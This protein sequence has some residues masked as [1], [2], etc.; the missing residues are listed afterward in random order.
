MPRTK[1]IPP[2]GF[3]HLFSP[4]ACGPLTLKNRLVALPVHTGF[5]CP[6]G[7]VST[8]MEKFYTRLAASG[9]ALVVVANAA[10]SPD[11]VVS[12]FNLRADRDEFIPGLARLAA[13]V[14][15]R[16]A[17][18]CLQLNHAG[19][20]AKTQRPL[21]PSPIIAGNLAFNVESLK[22][23]MEFFPF[24]KRFGLTR[25]LISKIRTWGS[26]MTDDDRERVIRDF[27]AAAKRAAEAGFDMVELHGANGYLLCQYLSK[28]TNKLTNE[29]GGSKRRRAAFPLAVIREIKKQV[30]QGFPFGFR[31]ILNEWVPGG[32]RPEEAADFAR[33]LEKEDA[34]YLSVSA[35][36]YN[37]LFTLEVRKKMAVP[38]YLE[39]ETAGLARQITTPVIISGR[40]TTP[41]KA[42]SVIRKGSADL[43]G[44][45]R[46]LRAD[47]EWPAKARGSGKK[48]IP[49]INCN[50]CIKQVIL[51]K[52]FLCRQ[53]PRWRQEQTLLEHQLL[54][55]NRRSLWIAAHPTDLDTFKP[56]LPLLLP[57]EK[58]KSDHAILLRCD[59]LESQ[60][61][62][63]L[64]Q[65]FSAWLE[66]Q[67][68]PSGLS[69]IPRTHTLAASLD[70]FE[71]AIEAE[72]R[73]GDYGIT[74]LAA[75]PDQPW[76]THLLYRIRGK[77]MVL[78]NTHPR[79]F[80]VIVP[81][82]LSETTLLLL[83][84]LGQT[85]MQI[86]LFS[87]DFIHIETGST[88]AAPS[89]TWNEAVKI[90]GM[91][92][93]I[94]LERI[95]TTSEVVPALAELIHRRDYGTIA[96]GKR[97]ISGIKRWLLGSVSAGLL[98]QLNDRSLFL[99]D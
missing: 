70:T 27:G 92:R 2:Q 62:D 33:C 47:P 84:T 61:L 46:P 38:A 83:R 91:D 65:G 35:A 20:F 25:Y 22:E 74:F 5:A 30:P 85:L 80:R 50:H 17:M 9:V 88:A 79:P 59:P 89:L 26:P 24:E 96:M 31:L 18:A 97:G 72:I 64:K 78:L 57:P 34:A 14:K 68:A 12:R 58:K 95:R 55:R 49:C 6:D 77:T 15:A 11:G 32:I 93:S 94:P 66:C 44:L 29:F 63:T 36:T 76:Q 90:T 56:F 3:P 73:Q 37:S 98:R 86:P 69:G 81:I 23:F 53:W 82:D 40:I 21:L 52:G 16:G 48:I 99:I 1:D 75:R 39:K 71:E 8:W 60:N 28:F 4:L 13:A 87:F 67:F 41:A 45:G 19:R 42:A 51:E 43:I 54:T 10:V 7:R